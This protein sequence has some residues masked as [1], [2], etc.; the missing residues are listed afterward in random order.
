MSP[1]R[2]RAEAHGTF[3]NTNVDLV[4]DLAYNYKLAVTKS[5]AACQCLSLFNYYIIVKYEMTFQIL[6]SV[7]LTLTER[8]NY[9]LHW[10]IGKITTFLFNIDIVGFTTIELSF[11]GFHSLRDFLVNIWYRLFNSHSILQLLKY[12]LRKLK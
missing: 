2:P 1:K 5:K 6:F 8:V 9:I 4:V 12:S 10:E 3:T 11:Y 7:M